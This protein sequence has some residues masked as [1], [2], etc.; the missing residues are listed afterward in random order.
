MI[1]DDDESEIEETI[2]RKFYSSEMTEYL[3]LE[4]MKKYALQNNSDYFRLEIL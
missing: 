1:E 2:G 3:Y 4:N